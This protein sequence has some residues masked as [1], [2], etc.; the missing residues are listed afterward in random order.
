[1]FGRR[2]EE[3]H[4]NTS[5]RGGPTIR[6]DSFDVFTVLYCS[7]ANRPK[8]DLQCLVFKQMYYKTDMPGEAD[9]EPT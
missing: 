9:T 1:M 5:V 2:V 8:M 6:M 4:E 3:I 7:F